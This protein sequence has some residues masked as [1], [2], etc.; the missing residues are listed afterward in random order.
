[1][2]NLKFLLISVVILSSAFV[3]AQNKEIINQQTNKVDIIS[4]TEQSLILN[5]TLGNYNKKPVTIQGSTFY[6]V[7]IPEGTQISEQ[8]YPDLAKITQS[9]LIPN[10][11]GVVANVIETQYEDFDFQ[12]A[13]SKGILLRTI[14]P[15][16]VPY[17]FSDVYS[18]NSFFPQNLYELGSPYLIKDKRGMVLNI[19]PFAYNPVQQKLR[20]YTQLKIQISFSGTNTINSLSQTKN[21]KNKYFDGIWK[22]HFL[23]YS[24]FERGEQSSDVEKMLIICYDGFLNE[25]QPFVN[26]KNSIGLP[27]EMVSVSAAG[28][29]SAAIKQFIQN[30]YNADNQLTFVLLVGDNNQVPTF[31][32]SGKGSDPSYS[33]L[34]GNDSYPDIFV[35]RFSA[36]NVNQVNTMVNRTIAYENMQKEQTMWYN[37]GLGIASSQGTGDDGEYDYEHLR[38]IRQEL[39]NWHYT[40]VSELYDGSQGVVDAAGNP[41][42]SMVADVV[43]NGVSLINYTGHGDVDRW[44]TSIF[45]NSNVNSLINSNFPF[46]FSVACLNG[47]FVSSTCFAETWLRASNS[48]SPTGA[49]GFYGASISQPWSPPMEA[50]DKFNELLT[51]EDFDTYSELCFNGSC[52]MI[53]KYGSSGINTFLTWNYFGDPSVSFR[54]VVKPVGLMIRDYLNDDGT[55]PNPRAITWNS[56]DIQLKDLYGTEITGCNISDHESGIVWVRVWNKGT[57]PSQAGNK[58]HVYWANRMFLSRANDFIAGG[59]FTNGIFR[60]LPIGQELTPTGG[61]TINTPIPAGNYVEVPVPFNIPNNSPYIERLNGVFP[62]LKSKISWRFALMAIIDEAGETPI[63]SFLNAPSATLAKQYNNV[64]VDNGNVIFKSCFSRLITL[65]E[66]VAIPFQFNVGQILKDGKYLLRDFAELNIILS[67]DLMSKLIKNNQSADGFKIKDDY[68]LL[69]TSPNATLRFNAIG[70]IDA[71][72]VAGAEVHFIS[73]KYPE[74]ND[75]DFD[76]TLAI[77]GETPEIMRFTAVR[78]E[79]VYFKALAEASKTKVVRA[80]EEVTL[81]SNQIFD[82]AYYTWYDEAGEK[83]GTGYQITITPAFSQKYKIEILKKEDGFKSYDEI[84]VIVVDGVIA[85]LSPNPANS[86]V[87]V[88][89]KLSDNSTNASVQ[90]SDIQ[91]LVSVSYPLSTNGTYQEISLSG[92]VSGTYF[93]KLIISG[94]VADTKSLIIY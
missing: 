45:T 65:D 10:S 49:I 94:V 42:V 83:I 66:L 33:L 61:F 3:G 50:Q 85:A 56:P 18:Q 1:M 23:N 67:P 35:G 55:E 2:K 12:V 53:D 17:T 31:I 11:S 91:N 73:D 88:D 78:D 26:H 30:K 75:F 29:T 19:Y 8:G 44:V 37:H 36:E 21:L 40:D 68:T 64:A 39:L 80:K 90:I 52:S 59:I 28:N 13:P 16:S 60:G 51:N 54:D 72:L 58:L 57:T 6:S 76:F 15:D 84:E 32:V 86:Y 87:R 71:E 82:D 77:D 48:Q 70:N 63:T 46:I 24:T 92:F 47:D 89:Y 93:V 74:L 34:S 38:N 22:N 69:I 20:I 81:T 79:N 25:M 43:N 7:S 5:V 14:N 41:T 9:I 27:T 62:L 4:S